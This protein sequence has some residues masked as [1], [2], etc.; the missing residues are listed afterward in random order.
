L[1]W[2]REQE[3]RFRTQIVGYEDAPGAWS[4]QNFRDFSALPP[5]DYVL[6]VEARD[7]AGNASAPLDVPFSVTARWWQT[8]AARL[9]FVLLGAALLWA[10]LQWRTLA[11][12]AQRRAL[13]R[14]VAARTQELNAANARLLELSYR[15]A[16]TGLANRRRLLETLEHE[17]VPGAPTA[18]IFLDVDLFKEY[19]DHFGHPA[20]DEALRCVARV[21]AECAPEHALAARYGGEEFAC[22][23]PGMDLAPAMALAER[24]RAAVAACEIAVP[25][26]DVRRRVTISAGVAAERLASAADAHALLRRADM[27]LYR[28]K[29]DGRNCVRSAADG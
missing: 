26:A 25:G 22:L 13:E 28:A 29:S 4:G 21:L 1:S 23:V 7:Y 15:D 24:V 3:S 18:L 17:P 11:L 5:G 9:A 27:A 8:D 20:G 12:R 10:L 16:L 6:H 19:N 14:R 2:R